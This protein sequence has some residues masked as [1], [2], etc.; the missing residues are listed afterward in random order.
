MESVENQQDDHIEEEPK[1]EVLDEKDL[2]IKDLEKSLVSLQEEIQTLR[3]G[4]ADVVNRNKQLE[5]DKKYASMNLAHNLLIPISYFEGALK[6]KSEDPQINNFLKGFEMVYN[7]LL[8]QLYNSGLKEIQVK[9]N[10]AYDTKSHEVFEL[11]DSDTEENTI[12][13]IVQKGYY[14]KERVLKPTKVKV[15]KL[16][17][18]DEDS[19]EETE[20][21][22]NK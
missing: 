5:V 22:D 1:V 14:F 9:V 16:K 18:A 7:L 21:L 13:E 11:V 20:N 19:E 17:S 12:V 3:K 10:D 6:I 2:K 15:T 4:A 8:E